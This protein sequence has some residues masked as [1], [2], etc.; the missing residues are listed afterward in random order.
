MFLK[1]DFQKAY[2]RLDWAFL[3]Q[4]L[5]W[6]GFDDMMISWIMQIAM[7]GNTAINTNREVGPYFRSSCGVR[8]GDPIS[9]LLFNAAVDVL[10]EILKK[11]K[12]FRPHF[13]CGRT[14]HLK[15][16]D[17]TMIMVEGLELDLANLKF[18]LLCFEAM[19]GLKINF[20]KSE[21]VVMGFDP[22]EQQWIVDNRNYRLS[23]FPVNYLGMPHQD[24]RI[25][26]KD[27]DP[28]VGR[29]KSKAE[30]WRWKFTSNGSKIVLIKS[31]LASLPMYIMGLYLLPEGVH[32]NFDKEL[33]RFFWQEHNGRQ[34]YHMVKWAD[35]TGIRCRKQ[36]SSN[37]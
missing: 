11:A 24:T 16:A 4:A 34:K 30:P 23:A 31:C 33:S 9:P 3:Q 15:Y 6:R 21:V 7:S 14:T 27:L 12:I 28:L 10:A 36:I 22:N 26:I 25:L 17:D 18:I 19:S 1:R 5:I 2:D 20:D 13:W 35:F 37:L 29:A 32:K 8:Q